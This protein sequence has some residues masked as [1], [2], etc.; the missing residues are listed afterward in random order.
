VLAI[1]VFIAVAS[2]VADQTLLDVREIVRA[3][4]ERRH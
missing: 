2:W 3:R 4:R 1:I